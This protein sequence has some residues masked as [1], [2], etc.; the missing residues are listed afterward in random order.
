M[1]YYP[2]I[3][4]QAG[5]VHPDHMTIPIIFFAQG[6]FSLEDQARYLTDPA[7]STGPSALNAR[8][9]GD[10]IMV[11]DFALMRTELSSMFQRSEDVWKTSPT[12]RKPVMDAN[13]A[14]R[15]TPGSAGIP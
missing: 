10:L 3:I 15:A 1:R 9:H 13:T 2:G 12:S 14:P 6:E 5:D 4:K 7:Q 8:A 11:H